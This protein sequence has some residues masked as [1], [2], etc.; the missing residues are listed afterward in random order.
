MELKF[1]SGDND[2]DINNF[3]KVMKPLE[4]VAAIRKILANKKSHHEQI[5]QIKALTEAK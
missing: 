5:K 3:L 1:D 2:K 4:T